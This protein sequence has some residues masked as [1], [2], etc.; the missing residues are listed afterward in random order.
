MDKGSQFYN[1]PMKWWLR[2]NDIVK[3]KEEKSVIAEKFIRN[4]KIKI[5]K[6]MTSVLTMSILTN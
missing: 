1:R 5:Y 6:Y 2:E 3:N 4:L